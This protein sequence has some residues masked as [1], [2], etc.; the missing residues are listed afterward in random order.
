MY[1]TQIVG[2]K[3][4]ILIFN[5]RHYLMHIIWKNILARYPAPA[6]L[7]GTFIMDG[8]F[9]NCKHEQSFVIIIHYTSFD[10]NYK[11]DKDWNCIYYIIYMG[12]RLSYLSEESDGLNYRE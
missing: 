12:A 10:P 11:N 4:G 1:L 3:K 2:A 5:F 8:Q 9:L 7:S 6:S